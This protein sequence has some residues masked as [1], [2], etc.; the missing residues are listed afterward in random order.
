MQNGDKFIV[1]EN[2]EP[3]LVVMSFK[4]YE[5]IMFSR[6]GN[7]ARDA[8]QKKSEEHSFSA[9]AV[10]IS[11]K[12]IMHVPHDPAP[13]SAI[14]VGKPVQKKE[15]PDSYFH[16]WRPAGISDEESEIVVEED[17][18]D[19]ALQE[20]TVPLP[21]ELSARSEHVRLEDLPI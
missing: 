20:E 17:G 16:P 4:E 13:A 10:G 14:P 1:V 12:G 7:G 9:P 8:G 11:Q 21:Y 19:A 2:E 3:E 6:N 18:I 5:K 15:S